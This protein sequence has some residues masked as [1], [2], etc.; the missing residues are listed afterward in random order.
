MH[1]IEKYKVS[2]EDTIREAIEKMDRGGIGFCVCINKSG[3]VVGVVSDGDFRRGVLAKVNIS[4]GIEKILNTNYFYVNESY[5]S[6]EIDSIF[7]KTVAENIPV[8]N[9]GE[10]VEIIRKHNFY[11]K[12]TS[13]PKPS[14]NNP[15]VIMAGG[16]GI[17][18]G[19]FTRILPKPLIPIGKKA[20]IEIIMDG[21]AS[22]GM[23][24]YFISINHKGRMIKAFFADHSNN[25]K[26]EYLDEDKPLGTAGGLQ[27]LSG[28]IEDT[29]FVSNC[30]IIINGDYSD[31]LEFHKKSENI[32]TIVA[33][34]QHQVI[35]YGVCEIENEGELKTIIEK[36]EYNHLVNT[37]MYI[38]EPKALEA[39]PKNEFYQMTDLINDL[40]VQGEKIGVYPISESKWTDIGEWNKFEQSMENLIDRFN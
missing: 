16:K 30:D 26:I 19:P 11:D 6:G 12:K 40:K 9:D 25:Y 14:L 5:S 8:I 28:I 37:G 13:L 33:S 24:K 29:I 1:D 39:I 31:M 34:M 21:F 22:Y 23:K 10:L 32:L 15:V 17:R 4:D 18:M 35:P 20:V 27:Y 2:I 7:S 38:I 36:P 3:K